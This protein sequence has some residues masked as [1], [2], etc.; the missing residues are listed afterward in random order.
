M[1]RDAK[2]NTPT[3]YDEITAK[4]RERL[5]SIATWAEFERYVAQA[6]PERR[7]L[8][9]QMCKPLLPDALPCCGPAF[10]GEKLGKPY[11]HSSYCPEREFMARAPDGQAPESQESTG[12]DTSESTAP[13]TD[14]GTAI[15]ERRPESHTDG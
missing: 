7:P 10:L 1:G 3:S 13:A 11:T 14:I 5:S 8:I 9:R 4:L 2:R 6:P 12:H 15:G